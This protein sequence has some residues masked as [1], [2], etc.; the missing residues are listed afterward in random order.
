MSLIEGYIIGLGMII[1]VGPVFFLLLNSSLQ[2]G[3][4]AG[5]AVALGIIFSDV[6]CVFLCYYGISTF[7][8]SENHQFWIG[9]LGS[10]ILLTLGIGYLLKKA[11]STF[12]N[13][14]IPK[15]VFTFFVKGFSV[16]FFNPF[17]FAVWIGLFQYGKSKYTDIQLWTFITSILLGI[18]T[19]DL[20]KV[21]LAEKVKTFISPKRLTLLFKITGVVLILFAIRLLYMVL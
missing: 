21:F 9:L 12:T 4:K 18:L 14:P 7:F 10:L 19:I 15:R 5:V 20:L 2:F 13:L 1:F 6:I 17:V 3:R 16:N 11:P 8:V